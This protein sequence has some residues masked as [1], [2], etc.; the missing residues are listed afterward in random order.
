MFATDRI[1]QHRFDANMARLDIGKTIEL[2]TMGNAFNMNAP[3]KTE[4]YAETRRELLPYMADYTSTQTAPKSVKGGWYAVVTK[5]TGKVWLAQTKNFQGTLNRFRGGMVPKEVEARRHEGLAIFLATK[6][7]NIDE[8]FYNLDEANLLLGR[9]S[10]VSSGEGRLYVISHT[11][12]HY[13]LTKARGE[14]TDKADVLTRFIGRVLNLAQTHHHSTNQLLQAFVSDN[15]GDLLREKGFDVREVGKFKDSDDAVE[16][17]N[18]YYIEQS[19]MK[20][21]NHVFDKR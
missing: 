2:G 8:L 6:E 16:M 10:R 21:L 15:A 4:A 12:G 3:T 1:A 14:N 18:Q 5:E 20:C 9:G 7:I 19:H 17:M 13:Y 11:S